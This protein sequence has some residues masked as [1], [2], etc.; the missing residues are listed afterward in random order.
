MNF[1][2]STYYHQIYRQWLVAANLSCL[3]DYFSNFIYF[4]YEE[5]LVFN[6]FYNLV[7]I[8]KIYEKGSKI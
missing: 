6:I 3:S 2:E 4:K 8:I 1:H 5:N 7:S